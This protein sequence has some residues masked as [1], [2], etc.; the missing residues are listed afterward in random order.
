MTEAGLPIRPR[1]PL[2][3]TPEKLVGQLLPSLRRTETF[4]DG[5][6]QSKGD[7]IRQA[8]LFRL[9]SLQQSDRGTCNC[10]VFSYSLHAPSCRISLHLGSVDTLLPRP[11]AY[12]MQYEAAAIAKNERGLPVNAAQRGRQ[13]RRRRLQGWLETPLARKGCGVF[14]EWSSSP[15]ERQLSHPF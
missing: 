8:L 13:F 3:L 1:H 5:A 7:A 11:R 12:A 14:L 6:L 9:M 2:R 15:S 10:R 4:R